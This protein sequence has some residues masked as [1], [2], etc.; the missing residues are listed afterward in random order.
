MSKSDLERT[1]AIDAAISLH[2]AELSAGLSAE[3]MSAVR[4]LHA[5]TSA[6]HMAAAENTAQAVVLAL[7]SPGGGLAGA[8]SP[9]SPPRAAQQQQQA[10]P[11]P[12]FSVQLSMADLLFDPPL[13]EQLRSAPRGSFGVVAFAQWRSHNLPCAVKLIAARSATGQAMPVMTWLGEAELM[14]RLREHRSA[15]TGLAPQHVVNIFGIGV[16]AERNGETKQYLVVM[17]RLQGSLRAALDAYLEKGRQ[18]P[19][20]QALQWLAQTAAGLAECRYSARAGGR[21]THHT[22]QTHNRKTLP[23]LSLGPPTTPSGPAQATRPTSCTATSR[24]RTRSSA[25]AAKRRSAIWERAASRAASARRR[26]SAA[27]PRRAMRAAAC[28]G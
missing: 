19:L 6:H 7:R 25:S 14:R 13:E 5:V 4:E 20:E 1:K 9:E 24:R 21:P 8:A 11:L 16:D 18:P 26:A 27:A 22:A 3:A 17:E 12:P 28:C 23:S 10:P 15:K 2:V